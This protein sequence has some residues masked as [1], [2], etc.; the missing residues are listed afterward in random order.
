LKKL[1]LSISITMMLTTL[2]LALAYASQDFEFPWEMSLI[3]VDSDC[4][5]LCGN[6]SA[7]FLSDRGCKGRDVGDEEVVVAETIRFC[8][9]K[10]AVEA[11]NMEKE[12]V[13]LAM[14]KR[15]DSL[16]KLESEIFML[17]TYER[18]MKLSVHPWQKFSIQDLRNI[19]ET[20]R[21]KG[22]ATSMRCRG[23]MTGERFR[24]YRRGKPTKVTTG[25]NS[26]D[27][28]SYIELK[29]PTGKIQVGSLGDSK[30]A[31]QRLPDCV[32]VV[33]MKYDGERINGI[34]FLSQGKET[35]FFGSDS[36]DESKS[37]IY[38]APAGRCLEDTKIRGDSLVD[39]LCIRFNG[40][41]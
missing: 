35:R 6:W 10:H 40:E 16:S 30:K 15:S 17:M 5:Q 23:K 39:R 7:L 1:F 21:I 34:Q 8:P 11:W 41:E 25:V 20:R 22:S 3:T 2:V 28:L 36:A 33:F 14:H 4:P 13:Y 38:V 18:E 24:H 37:Y 31:S 27:V 29:Y 12:L 9:D 32:Q 19:Q 26:D